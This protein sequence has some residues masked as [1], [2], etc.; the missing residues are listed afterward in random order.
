MR[1]LLEIVFLNSH[2]DG[3][4]LVP[5]IRKP[6]EVLAEVP[7]SEKSWGGWI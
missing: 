2:L 5:T 4:T 6:F 1:R 7:L 3:V